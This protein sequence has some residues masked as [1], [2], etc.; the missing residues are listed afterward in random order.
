[1]MVIWKMNKL[2][3]ILPNWP[4]PANVHA[5]QTTRGK[6]NREAGHSLAPYDSL[7]LG[8]HVK[9]NPIHVAQNRQLLSKHLP[10]EPVWLHQVH[11]TNVYNAGVV[12]AT[13][14]TC[15]PDADAS[16]TLRKNVVCVTMTADCLPVLLCD[17]N[18]TVV[19]AVHAGWRGLCEGA[20]EASI[21]AVCR[22]ANIESNQ[23]M[24]WLGPA[25]G[26]KAF[27]VG[28]EVRQQFMAKD[29]EAEAAFKVH[30]D[31]FLCD[32][33]QLAT[34]RLN[35]LGVTQIYGGGHNEKF[36]TFTDKE[37]FFSFRRDG[38]T[39]RM[40]TLIWLA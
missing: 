1:M 34:Q 14:T 26:P 9:D 13:Q 17:V 32:I 18:G 36:C 30:G 6:A 8:D 20:L 21:H 38:V 29:A 37:N 35:N 10:S 24:A 22:A 33:Y 23:L 2:D 5:L 12:D 40:A 39:G 27:E 25:I 4:S 15:A 16:F 11:G 28:A 3:F 7:N 31:K 19:S